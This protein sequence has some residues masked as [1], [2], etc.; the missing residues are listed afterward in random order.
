[1]AIADGG[2]SA[3]ATARTAARRR[4]PRLTARTPARPTPARGRRAAPGPAPWGPGRRRRPGWRWPRT[5]GRRPRS[6]APGSPTARAPRR[7]PGRPARAPARA[8]RR[9]AP[10]RTPRSTAPGPRVVAVGAVAAGGAA[11]VRCAAATVL[12]D[13][14]R[15]VGDQR[16]RRRAGD[17][18]RGRARAHLGERG[19]RQVDRHLHR[20]AH[21]HRRPVGHA[22]P[23]G[24]R[25]GRVRGVD[26]GAARE[27]RDRDHGDQPLVGLAP[28][29]QER[30]AVSAVADVARHGAGLLGGRTGGRDAGDGRV[31]ALARLAGDQAQLPGRQPPAA[32][33]HRPLDLAQREAGDLVDARVGGAGRLQHQADAL[34]LGER[35]Q[36]VLDAAVAL[37]PLRHRV[38]RTAP[39][40]GGS[41]RPR[42]RRR[43]P[44][45]PRGAAPRRRRAPRCAGPC[46]ARP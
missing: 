17:H 1:M 4:T 46:G 27:E 24:D 19:G 18:D 34:G 23:P 29:A 41:R 8:R 45:G 42:R 32:L 31:Q 38:D 20:R 14:V 21:A 25:R 36:A 43:R 10:G 15:V 26:R 6:H 28:R 13:G 5:N 12:P 39:P 35:R 7:R 30:P 16:Q 11:T 3:A 40:R 22:L 37:A 33:E 2:A 9:G 44:R